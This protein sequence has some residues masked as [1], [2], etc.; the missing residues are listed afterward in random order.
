MTTIP[1]K[2]EI[3]LSALSN[4]EKEIENEKKNILL[5]Y[6]DYKDYI[7]NTLIF[8][9][10]INVDNTKKVLNLKNKYDNLDVML[11]NIKKLKDACAISCENIISLNIEDAYLI[12]KYKD[13]EN[14]LF[15]TK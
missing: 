12:N 8:K 13:M 9:Y 5:E 11:L 1:V 3:I 10:I 15:N 4:L 6:N 14:A 7:Y 2:I